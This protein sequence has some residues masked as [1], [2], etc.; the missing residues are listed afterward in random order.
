MGGVSVYKISKK[1]EVV[2]DLLEGGIPLL[3]NMAL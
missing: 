1:N 2:I 3:F